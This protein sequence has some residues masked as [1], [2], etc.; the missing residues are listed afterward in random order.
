MEKIVTTLFFAI[1][2]LSSCINKNKEN[3]SYSEMIQSIQIDSLNNVEVFW[4]NKM[5][6]LRVYNRGDTLG[7]LLKMQVLNETNII[8]NY[9]N[10]WYPLDSIDN[11]GL[12]I[13]KDITKDRIKYCCTSMNENKFRILKISRDLI[14]DI[15][16]IFTDS[17]DY[18]YIPDS[19]IYGVDKYIETNNLKNVF[20]KWWIRN[21]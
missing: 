21:N 18:F 1:F 6:C 19:N 10:Q 2:F 12:L 3:N 9:K 13:S 8:F 4:R 20:G 5:I 15:K 7:Y 11:K 14:Y 17:I 16:I